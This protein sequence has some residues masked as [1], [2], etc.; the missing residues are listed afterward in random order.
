MDRRVKECPT[1]HSVRSV[2]NVNEWK[3]VKQ[4]GYTMEGL[5]EGY[6]VL[7]GRE[8]QSIENESGTF[9]DNREVK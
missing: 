6:Q 5:L 7:I 9:S 1:I 2:L 3:K 4:N 8:I